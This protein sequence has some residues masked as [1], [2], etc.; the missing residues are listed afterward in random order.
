[1]KFLNY[2]DINSMKEIL[3]ITITS[4]KRAKTK[5]GR[6]FQNAWFKIWCIWKPWFLSKLFWFLSELCLRILPKKQ[7]EELRKQYNEIDAIFIDKTIHAN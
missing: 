5:I 3:Q 1:M 6:F 4:K 2:I 7:R